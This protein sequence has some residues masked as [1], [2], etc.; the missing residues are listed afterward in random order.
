MTT[1]P[2]SSTQGALLAADF[3]SVN[4]RVTLWDVVDGD[5]GAF[6]LREVCEIE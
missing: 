6:D 3:G 4:T 2:P 1:T 5:A